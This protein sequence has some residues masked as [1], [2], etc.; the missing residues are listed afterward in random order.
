MAATVEKASS[1]LGPRSPDLP[2]QSGQVLEI[3]DGDWLHPISMARQ[4]VR[5]FSSRGWR[6]YA[7][8]VVGGGRW[9]VFGGSWAGRRSLG[10]ARER[11]S[12]DGSAEA[13]AAA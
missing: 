4:V 11:V 3:E 10:P 7:S 13:A 12:G 2:Y 1:H 6:V 9:R 5:G 8:M